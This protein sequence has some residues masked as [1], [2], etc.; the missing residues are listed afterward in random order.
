MEAG[1]IMIYG[2]RYIPS[3]L[4]LIYVIVSDDDGTMQ[5]VIKYPLIGV[6][7]QVLGRT[8]FT[9]AWTEMK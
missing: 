6:Q 9:F 5:S 8:F 1:E 2:R 4:I 3:L 7:C